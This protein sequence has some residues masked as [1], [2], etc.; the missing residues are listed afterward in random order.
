MARHGKNYC[1]SEVL[2]AI[3][4][5]EAGADSRSFSREI[6]LMLKSSLIGEEY[7][8]DKY[9]RYAGV[10]VTQ[11]NERR[12]EL[13]RELNSHTVRVAAMPSGHSRHSRSI[14]ME[15]EI[16]ALIRQVSITE[17]RSQ[18][19]ELERLLLAN[20]IPDHTIAGSYASH[21]EVLD[22]VYRTDK[23]AVPA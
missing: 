15:P 11:D 14:S 2:I 22:A 12:W 7:K 13:L 5:H 8:P 20:I 18:S 3:I 9:Q 1:L 23:E 17:S 19:R 6:N 10:F 21:Q 4:T 16:Q